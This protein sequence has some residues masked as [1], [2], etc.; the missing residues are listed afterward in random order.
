MNLIL[1]GVLAF[2]L[3]CLAL[4]TLLA[5]LGL[6]TLAAALRGVGAIRASV[7]GKG[8]RGMVDDGGRIRGADPLDY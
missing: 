8:G 3:V 2:P 1:S 4:L 5:L 6:L 7:L